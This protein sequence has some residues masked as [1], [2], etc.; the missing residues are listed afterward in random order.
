MNAR[1][2]ARLTGWKVDIKSDTEFATEEAEAAFAGDGDEGDTEFTGRCAAV[3]SNG[4]RCPNAALPGSRYCG[5]PA[6]QELANR[7]ERRGGRSEPVVDRVPSRSSRPRPSSP[8]RRPRASSPDSGRGASRRRGRGAGARGSR[9]RES[10]SPL[11]ERARSGRA[12]AA[13]A[14]PR[15][16]ELLRFVATRRRADA[17]AAADRDAASTRAGAS[18]ASSGR[19][20]RRAFNRTLRA[21][22]RVDP[23]LARLYT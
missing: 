9:R 2:A 15:R 23:E 14:R 3:L 18:P 1:L 8:S 21:T 11:R 12:P 13:A 17:C 20:E 5:V 19:V 10:A 6:H 22:V 4:K 7:P 16:R